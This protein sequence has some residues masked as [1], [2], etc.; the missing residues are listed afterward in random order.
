MTGIACATVVLEACTRN[1]IAVCPSSY[2]RLE[3]FYPYSAA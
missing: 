1:E 3:R 2:C